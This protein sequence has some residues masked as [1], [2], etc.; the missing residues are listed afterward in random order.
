[1]ATKGREW[2]GNLLFK[3]GQTGEERAS[4][5]LNSA[6]DAERDARLESESTGPSWRRVSAH[7]KD[8]GSLAQESG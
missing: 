1:M 6:A 4:W 7:K 5:R 2:E 3:G 8:G